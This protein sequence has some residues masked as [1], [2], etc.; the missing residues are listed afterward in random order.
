ML[1][2]TIVILQFLL[3]DSSKGVSYVLQRDNITWTTAA[4]RCHLATPQMAFSP[5][6]I[7]LNI[8]VAEFVR[9]NVSEAWI[10]YSMKYKIFQ[11]IGCMGFDPTVAQLLNTSYTTRK[12]PGQCSTACNESRIIGIQG[13]KCFCMTSTPAQLSMS[14]DTCVVTCDEPADIACGASTVISLFEAV[15]NSNALLNEITE[16]VKDSGN[17]VM[18]D[19]STKTFQWTRCSLSMGVQCQSATGSPSQLPLRD[20]WLKS[21]ISCFTYRYFPLNYSSAL[22]IKS[23]SDQVWTGMFRAEVIYSAYPVNQTSKYGYVRVENG[24]ANLLF[25][26]GSTSVTKV[27]LCQDDMMTAH[28]N[29]DKSG[30]TSDTATLL[31][32]IVVLPVVALVVFILVVAIL[33]LRRRKHTLVPKCSGDKFSNGSMNANG[34]SVKVTKKSDS[35]D[36]IRIIDLESTCHDTTDDNAVPMKATKS[37]ESLDGLRDDSHYNN[38]FVIQDPKQVDTSQRNDGFDYSAKSNQFKNQ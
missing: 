1:I 27:S 11:Y 35:Y 38:R 32:L 20:T 13:N 22:S 28:Q 5:A 18:Y 4:S 25:Y 33:L 9:Q 14:R 7:T 2:E 21:T 24:L 6:N 3:M 31:P 19:S 16:N 10:G 37:L 8:N 12:S 17:C 36:A 15:N 34:V 30:L 29:S 23:N 26:N